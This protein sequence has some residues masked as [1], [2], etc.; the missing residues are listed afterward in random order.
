MYE[1]IINILVLFL[2]VQVQYANAQNFLK[3]GGVLRINLLKFT[4]SDKLNVYDASGQV[5][6]I[7]YKDPKDD[8]YKVSGPGKNEIAKARAF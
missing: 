4:H 8:E 6:S 3:G 2:S 7:V 1:R 5:F